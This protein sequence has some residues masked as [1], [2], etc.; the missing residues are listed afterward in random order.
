MYLYGINSREPHRNAESSTSLAGQG[1]TPWYSP[2]LPSFRGNTACTILNS[3][4]AMT[5]KGVVCV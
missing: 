4:M 2:R 3:Y 5:S 1:V